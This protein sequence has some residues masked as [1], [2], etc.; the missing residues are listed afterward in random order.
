MLF[1]FLSTTDRWVLAGALFFFFAIF[2]GVN[3]IYF[4]I[5]ATSGFEE[6]PSY[7]PFFGGFFGVV[8]LLLMPAGDISDRLKWLWVPLLLDASCLP[9]VLSGLYYRFKKKR[10]RQ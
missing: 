5:K 8:G 9:L 2:A 1:D 4:C 3:F 7:A 6:G 10:S